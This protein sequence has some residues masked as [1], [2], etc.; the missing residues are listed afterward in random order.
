[1]KKQVYTVV[2]LNDNGDLRYGEF[3]SIAE[4]R[5]FIEEKIDNLKAVI[6]K[7]EFFEDHT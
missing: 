3:D 6:I 7:G 4:S 1:M 5:N 2:Y